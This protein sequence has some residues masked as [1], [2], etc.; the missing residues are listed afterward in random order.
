[1][2][3][4]LSP[5]GK[6]PESLGW[7]DLMAYIIIRTWFWPFIRV[8]LLTDNS[9]PLQYTNFLSASTLHLTTDCGST[10]ISC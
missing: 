8:K 1:M 9:C 10:A 6:T 4:P 2:L 7:K 3:V 5:A